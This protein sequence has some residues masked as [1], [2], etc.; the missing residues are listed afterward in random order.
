[1]PEGMPEGMEMDVEG[2]GD[3]LTGDMPDGAPLLE[4]LELGH[5][6]HMHL[7]SREAPAGQRSMHRHQI[8]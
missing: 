8:R 7:P 5:N 4:R 6:S 1:M 2:M 3:M